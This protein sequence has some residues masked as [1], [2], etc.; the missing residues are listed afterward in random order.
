MVSAAATFTK[1]YGGDAESAFVAIEF[2]A[3]GHIKLSHVAHEI[4]SDRD[5]HG[6]PR[7]CRLHPCEGLASPCWINALSTGLSPLCSWDSVNRPPTR[8][9]R[10]GG[11]GL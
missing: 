1:V 7:A 9:G 11:A 3:K 8:M 5:I 2:D 10:T 6:R 4:G